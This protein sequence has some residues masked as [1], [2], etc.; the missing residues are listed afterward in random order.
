MTLKNHTAHKF[1][2]KFGN[3]RVT[4]EREKTLFERL[5]KAYVKH[6]GELL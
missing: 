4:H 2:D 5:V 6:Y 1:R 3:N